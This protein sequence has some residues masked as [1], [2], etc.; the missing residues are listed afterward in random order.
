M[1]ETGAFLTSQLAGAGVPR[2]AIVRPGMQRAFRLPAR[3][4]IA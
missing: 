1:T 3:T 4:R 2:Q